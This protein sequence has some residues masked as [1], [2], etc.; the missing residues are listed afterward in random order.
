MR[1]PLDIY[2]DLTRAQVREHYSWMVSVKHARAAGMPA[3]PAPPWVKQRASRLRHGYN[4]Y[5]ARL[6]QADATAWRGYQ[7]VIAF[8]EQLPPNLQTAIRANLTIIARGILELLVLAGCAELE[9]SEVARS[10]Q[11]PLPN[12]G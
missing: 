4:E 1:K 9:K 6:F 3:P 8:A 11:G 7:S 10:L 5:E 2:G 12:R